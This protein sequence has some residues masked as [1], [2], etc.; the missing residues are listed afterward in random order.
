MQFSFADYELDVARRELR[1]RGEPIAMEPQVFDLLVH[2]DITS[3][4]DLNL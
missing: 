1:G 4:I 3:D 2:F